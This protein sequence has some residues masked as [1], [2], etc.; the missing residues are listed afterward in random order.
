MCRLDNAEE[1]QDPAP[2]V[3]GPSNV[4]PRPNNWPI[5]EVDSDEEGLEPNFDPEP[6]F[7]NF[8][9]CIV[10]FFPNAKDSDVKEKANEFLFGAVAVSNKRELQ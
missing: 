2:N 1:Q 10:T 8:I 3:P 7:G 4:K 9:Y 6:D 5:N